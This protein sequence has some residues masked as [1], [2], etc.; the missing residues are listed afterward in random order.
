MKQ[1]RDLGQTE[2]QSKRAWCSSAPYRSVRG[3]SVKSKGHL[4]TS[5]SQKLWTSHPELPDLVRAL[6]SPTQGG[7]RKVMCAALTQR[8]IF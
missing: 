5:F 7:D 2:N 3:N 8:C 1:G 6:S 4:R